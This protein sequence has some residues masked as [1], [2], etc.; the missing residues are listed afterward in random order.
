[1]TDRVKQKPR[2]LII[3]LGLIGASFAKAL[4]LA[5][6]ARVMGMDAHPGVADQALDLGIIDEKVEQL[7]PCPEFDVVILAVP[8]LAM[9]TVL[10]QLKPCLKSDTV[11]SDVG[12]VKG[13][14]VKAAEAAL[15]ELPSGFVPGH[16]IAGAERSGVTAAK[17][18]LFDRHLLILTPLPGSSELAISLLTRLWQSVGAEVVRM[19]VQRHDEV[20]AATSHLP[21]LLAFSLVDTLSRDSEHREIFRYAAGGFR[22]F[23]R[24]AASD[25]TMW[26]DVFLANRDATLAILNRF[27]QDLSQLASAIEQ[28]D[29]ETLLGVFGRA[30]SARDYFTQ[31]LQSRQRISDDVR[32]SLIVAP[33]TR[34]LSSWVQPPGDRSISH[35]A[36]ILAALSDGQCMVRGF[37]E[38][39]DN[40]ATLEAL[41]KLGVSIEEESSTQLRVQGVGLTG[42]K[43]PDS[44][45]Y[46]ANSAT[47]MRLLAGVLAAQGFDCELM[48]DASLSQRPMDRIQTPLQ[49]MG[50]ALDLS[51]QGTAPIMVRARASF[52]SLVYRL[53]M[54]SAQVKSAILLASLCAGVPVRLQEP[55]PS[56]D[57]TERLLADLGC[58]FV[59]QEE[60]LQFEPGPSIPAFDID[61]PGDFSVAAVH[62]AAATLVPGSQINLLQVG[63]NPT[64][65]GFLDVLKDMGGKIALHHQ[66][67]VGG[68]PVADIQ[69]RYA[70][71]K[72]SQVSAQFSGRTIDEFP[73]LFVLAALAEGQSRFSGV[74]ELR[75]KET[76]RLKTMLE[77]LHTL[78]ARIELDGDDVLIEGRAGEP[79]NGGILDCAGDHRVALAF[80]VAAQVASRPVIIRHAGR[81]LGA[82]PCFTEDAARLGYAVTIED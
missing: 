21:H 41:R 76:D 54:A 16:P 69:V 13:S 40:R 81:L 3:G 65:L 62:M 78:G 37:G 75:Y 72:A 33:A 39:D 34:A 82:Y 58:S 53:P 2:V 66:R 8:V 36:I 38:G 14:V 71:L 25:P 15:G 44:P 73:L 59:R 27:Q 1:M 29:G 5:Q 46:L 57:H 68:E 47:S 70:P 80:L 22:D 28:G 26:H 67:K 50:A 20:L 10:K 23:T 48:G 30:K 19:P 51:A 74:R 11:I 35:R 55:V 31:I 43:K 63:V 61:I 24:I 79:F 77:G 60:E 64:R 6:S 9:E 52:T 42:L 45:I 4:R 12:S 18:D 56:R 32:K 49:Q 17:A 7:S